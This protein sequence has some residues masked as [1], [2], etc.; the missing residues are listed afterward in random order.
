VVTRPAAGEL[1]IVLSWGAAPADLDA[2]LWVPQGGSMY[3]VEPWQRGSLTRFPWALLHLQA[4]RGL[5]PEL[6]NVSR[7]QAGRSTFAVF[8][9]SAHDSAGAPALAGSGAVVEVYDQDGLRRRFVAPASGAGTWWTVFYYIWPSRALAA[10][11]TLGNLPLDAPPTVA[12]PAGNGVPAFRIGRTEVSNTQFRACVTAG[13]C[14]PPL[15]TC[16]YDNAAYANH[17][18][19]CVTR[20]NARR[21]AQW[22]SGTL[23]TAAQWLRACQGGDRRVYPWGSQPPD[24]TR[25]NYYPGTGPVGRAM[26][27]GSY[28]AGAS[29][30][31]AHDMAGNVAEYVE[32]D[33]TGDRL[34]AVRGGSFLRRSRYAACAESDQSS[35]AGG[36]DVGF[37]VV[38]AGP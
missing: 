26:A 24:T 31:G 13:V 23:P 30:Y 4:T 5:G 11:N 16:N 34:V 9:R 12:V 19:V 28:P 32:Q 36:R 10:V 35:S 8:N 20:D 6:I 27:V 25:A 21:Y 15:T 2:F 38:F 33:G 17:P 1:R 7:V 22:V 29:P 14:L 3:R 18:V 37:R